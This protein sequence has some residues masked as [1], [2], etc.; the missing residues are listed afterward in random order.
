M[1]SVISGTLSCHLTK[2]RLNLSCLSKGI[3]ERVNSYS[4]LET[5]LLVTLLGVDDLV[6]GVKTSST[7]ESSSESK[8]NLSMF[9]SASKSVE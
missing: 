8:L 2:G 4:P 6:V 1:L 5:R 3:G 9:K 7:R